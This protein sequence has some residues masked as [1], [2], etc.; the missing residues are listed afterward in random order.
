MHELGGKVVWVDADQRIR[1][2]RIRAANRGRG[3]ED[4]I[5]FEDFQAHEAAEMQSS[6]DE[7]TLNMTAVK[8]HADIT[9]LNESEIKHLENVIAQLL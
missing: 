6:G 5:T 8:A 9:I 2:E 4:D 3:S 1:Y 7:A